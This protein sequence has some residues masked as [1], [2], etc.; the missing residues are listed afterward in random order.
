M[1]RAVLSF[2]IFA[3]WG[4]LLHASEVIFRGRSYTHLPGY[5]LKAEEPEGWLARRPESAFRDVHVVIQM[6]NVECDLFVL[7]KVLEDRV[8]GPDDRIGATY[9]SYDY[10]VPKLF[11]DSL[12]GYI[13]PETDRDVMAQEI[14]R[15]EAEQA[16]RGYSGAF[17]DPVFFFFG[18]LRQELLYAAT[19]DKPAG[20][21]DPWL[22]LHGAVFSG[23]F[24][25]G[26]LFPSYGAKVK[27][28]ALPD[29]SR[30]AEP[31]A[32][33]TGG[34]RPRPRPAAD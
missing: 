9:Y 18:V 4:E 29:V 10:G 19:D 25:E 11:S 30:Y 20:Y 7:P 24:G 1:G 26:M 3:L 15:C 27:P 32:G 23:E 8:L 34:A 33:P 14:A 2:A 31:R 12:H 6:S 22:D 5:I 16:A 28:R 21:S 17:S 13:V